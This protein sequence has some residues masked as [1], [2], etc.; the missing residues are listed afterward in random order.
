MADRGPTAVVLQETTEAEGDDPVSPATTNN[1]VVAKL[2]AEHHEKLRIVRSLSSMRKRGLWAFTEAV[3]RPERP[4]QG[5]KPPVCCS[6][7][8][9]NSLNE[10]PCGSF[11]RLHMERAWEEHGREQA[12]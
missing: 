2:M 12:V 11:R 5:I 1:V 6:E 7:P 9:L 4:C 10:A 3:C 8:L